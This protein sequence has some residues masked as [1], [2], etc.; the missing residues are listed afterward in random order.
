MPFVNSD[1]ARIYW[2]IDGRPESPPLM[3]VGSLGSDHAMWNPVIGA[4]TRFFRV[5]RIDKR[6][7]GASDV[8]DGD[9]KME[10]LARDVLAV[11]DKLGLQRFR[12]LGLSIGGMIGMQLA[13]TAGERI[14]RMVLSN[15]SARVDPGMWAERIAA[16]R[17][18]G[19]AAIADAVIGRFFTPA[20]AARNTEHYATVRQ[21]LLSIEPTG[22]I[23]CC[24]A[25]RDMR[26]QPL[27]PGI[28][29]PTLV[30][31]GSFDPSTP[32]E[33][34]RWIAQTIPNAH[35]LELPTAHFSP[36][37]EPGRYADAVVRF[38]LGND[39]PT[40]V[41]GR[42]RDENDRF[43]Q[44]LTRR[45][46]VM[47]DAYVDGRRSSVDDFTAGFDD[48]I[49]RYAW[50]EVWT[51]PALDDRTR[52]LLVIAQLLAQAR[53]DEFRLHVANGLAAELD[54]GELEALLMQSAIYCGMPAANTAFRHAAELL[55]KHRADTAP[56]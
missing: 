38:L 8:P 22:Y 31:S 33:Q 6:G 24:T 3:V 20:Y 16:I 14:E 27:L 46:Q 4:L 36:S 56:K 39:A 9:Y 26:L 1:G 2:R 19:M 18:G 48:L 42:H 54:A 30:V 32:P 21:T 25:I 5:V 7:H 13:G 53:W 51:G 23:G 37:E 28:Q 55:R 12:Y 47:G 52:R 29:T 50:G 49:T 44:G 11:A 41:T 15:T 40:S 34:G 45:R 17:S 43:D 10:Q 35:Y